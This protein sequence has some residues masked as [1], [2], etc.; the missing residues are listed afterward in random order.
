MYEHRMISE[1]DTGSVNS[2]L[3]RPISFYEFYLGQFIG[4]KVVGAAFSLSIPVMLTFFIDLPTYIWRL[5]LALLLVVF[6]LVFVHTLSFCVATSA[7]FFNRTH[8]FTAAKNIAIWVLAG[9]IFPL[10]LAP[11][12]FRGWMIAL[13]FSSGVFV[14]VGYLVGRVGIAEVQ[15][16]FVSVTISLIVVGFFAYVLWWSGRRV[17]SGT[18]A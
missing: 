3:V 5:P 16:A 6:Y 1:I 9:E 15:A 12:P 7:F 10:D 18:G 13:P 14:P 11:E 4:Y 8:G 17:Y 2:I